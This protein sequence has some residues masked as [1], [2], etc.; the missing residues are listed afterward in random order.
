[1]AL[2]L[3]VVGWLDVWCERRRTRFVDQPVGGGDEDL[4]RPLGS[5]DDADGQAH[6]P[7]V[8]VV[9]PLS[10]HVVLRPRRNQQLLTHREVLQ[11]HPWGTER[12]TALRKLTPDQLHP[13]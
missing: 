3:C 11:Q 6:Q 8:D 1:M 4:E 10:H 9:Q 5:E 13:P 7:L 12:D 2:W